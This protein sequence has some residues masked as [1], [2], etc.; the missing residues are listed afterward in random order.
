MEKIK[1]LK[2]SKT[3]TFGPGIKRRSKYGFCMPNV[4]LTYE[5]GGS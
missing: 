2:T 5:K 3:T 1:L 4:E